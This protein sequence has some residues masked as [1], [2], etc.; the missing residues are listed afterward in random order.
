M[1]L[2]QKA[3]ASQTFFSAL[4]LQPDLTRGCS[5]RPFA[6]FAI[7]AALPAL[8]LL[9][10]VEAGDEGGIG[11]CCPGCI[12]GF[13]GNKADKGVA[14]DKGVVAVCQLSACVYVGAGFLVLHEGDPKNEGLITVK[15]AATEL[16]D[17]F[18]EGGD[19]A[20]AQAIGIVYVAL[21]THRNGV[22]EVV[23]EPD[24]LHGPAVFVA[25]AFH[26]PA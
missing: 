21:A 1:Q 22:A 3:V 20:V 6:Q 4:S 23:G 19:V 7:V 10:Y 26:I 16:L 5:K 8:H 15:Q 17:C 2:Y 14:A 18:H 9:E 13:K 25:E 12:E 11:K 24:G